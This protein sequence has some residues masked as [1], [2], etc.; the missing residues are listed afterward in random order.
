MDINRVG[1]T[2]G[3]KA[4]RA[5]ILKLKIVELGKYLRRLIINF[6]EK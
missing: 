1:Q 3:D 5:R 2:N 6:L 4:F